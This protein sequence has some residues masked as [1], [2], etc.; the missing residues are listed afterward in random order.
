MT[1]YDDFNQDYRERLERKQNLLL[2]NLNAV[3]TIKYLVSKDV[4]SE[5]DVKHIL[6]E[7]NKEKQRTQFLQLMLD[8]HGTFYWK[9]IE[10][11]K[12]T[13]QRKIASLLESPGR[14]QTAYNHYCIPVRSQ[15]I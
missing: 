12:K 5:K 4:L 15:I 9:F 10:A 14:P 13:G 6:N 2:R 1:E 11:L 7:K 3:D 8:G